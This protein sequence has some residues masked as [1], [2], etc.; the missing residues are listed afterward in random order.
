MIAKD[1]IGIILKA[2][3]FALLWIAVINCTM[4][5]VLLEGGKSFFSEQYNFEYVGQILLFSLG[6]YTFDLMIQ[7][8]YAIR[9]RLSRR[10]ITHIL[11]SVTVC[12]LAVSI[13]KNMEMNNGYLLLFVGIA[14]GYMKAYTLY[15]SDKS[16]KYSNK[17]LIRRYVR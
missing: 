12:V 1:N 2:S 17:R 6:I 3:V 16:K 14:M 10:F 4:F 15:V 13:T 11:G 7:V 8:L 9:E 5:P